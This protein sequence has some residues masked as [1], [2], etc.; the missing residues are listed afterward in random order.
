MQ[1]VCEKDKVY[2]FQF[3]F[4]DLEKLEKKHL[5]LHAISGDEQSMCTKTR[6]M[7]NS[8]IKLMFAVRP[9]EVL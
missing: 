6:L 3:Y 8:S 7:N 5:H 2:V 1:Y 9:K 4:R